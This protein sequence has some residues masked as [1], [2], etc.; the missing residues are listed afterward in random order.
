M[1]IINL[2]QLQS[3]LAEVITALNSGGLIIFPTE[4]CYGVGVDATNHEAVSKL[5]AYK[6]RPAGKP[7][8]VAVAT[9]EQAFSL[10]KANEQNTNVINN[11]LPGPV[12][13]VGHS[14]GKVDPRLE[15]ELKTLGV[16]IP[17]Y[18]PLLELLTAWGK[19]LT[20][21]SA[22][23]S[24]GATPYNPQALLASLSRAKKA[25]IDLLIDAGELEP[26]P[27]SLVIDTTGTNQVFRPGLITAVDLAQG[28]S[29]LSY[30]PADT[31][32]I[33]ANFL[34]EHDFT[35][36]PTLLVYLQGELG[37]GKTQF[38]GGLAQA[39]GVKQ[40]VNSPSFNLASEYN[41][42]L[43]NGRNGKFHHLDL[44]RVESSISLADLD[45]LPTASFPQ[46][47]AIEWP[48][49]LANH[50]ALPSFDVKILKLTATARR[51]IITAKPVN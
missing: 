48:E 35:N 33:A 11:F 23:P 37:A 26:N 17:G 2:T 43:E 7:I 5:L 3:R 10:I 51:I 40:V 22:N 9:K 31:K 15:S 45:I 49:K 13:V 6:N 28:Q 21:T 24:G 46:V 30:S 4:T 29:Q 34:Q 50:P 20:A 44:W 18:P 12:T 39:L 25:A 14:T 16:R 42:T 47:I 1:Q 38:A 8:S 27:P 19:P 36:S 41:F 32:S